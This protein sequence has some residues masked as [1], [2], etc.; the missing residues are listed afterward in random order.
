MRYYLYMTRPLLCAAYKDIEEEHCVNNTE[1]ALDKNGVCLAVYNLL[2][3][4]QHILNV[5]LNPPVFDLV[6]LFTRV[7]DVLRACIHIFLLRIHS[8][9]PSF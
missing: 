6:H 5:P 1:K 7:A 2:L 4:I 8:V 9:R 3:V